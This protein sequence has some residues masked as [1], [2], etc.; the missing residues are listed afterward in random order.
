[1]DEWEIR[2]VKDNIARDTDGGSPNHYWIIKNMMDTLMEEMLARWNHT[3]LAISQA[4]SKMVELNMVITQRN[5]MV[6]WKRLAEG[7]DPLGDGGSGSVSMDP[8]ASIN[9]DGT[10]SFASTMPIGI[11][12][13]ISQ[14]SKRGRE[15]DASVGKADTSVEK[16]DFLWGKRVLWP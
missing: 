15:S 11:P 2:L 16:V 12:R 9:V 4:T 13:T 3:K 10:L 5:V 6:I 7:F 1:M 8:S 14:V